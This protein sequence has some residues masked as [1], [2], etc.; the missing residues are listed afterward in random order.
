MY[1]AQKIMIKCTHFNFQSFIRSLK[2]LYSKFTGEKSFQGKVQIESHMLT[3]FILEGW[4][5][6]IKETNF[7]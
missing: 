6:K 7:L 3:L 5:L 2:V 1:V 4:K